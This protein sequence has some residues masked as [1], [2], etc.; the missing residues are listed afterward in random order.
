MKISE[1][2]KQPQ[3]GN[4]LIIDVDVGGMVFQMEII[5]PVCGG[6]EYW[7]AE[8]RELLYCS[9]CRTTIAQRCGDFT[10]TSK[11]TWRL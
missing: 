5:C 10:F 3:E 11:G 2:H 6:R 4:N 7:L 1:E 8:G 9:K